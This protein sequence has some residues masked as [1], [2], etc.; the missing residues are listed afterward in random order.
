M[1]DWPQNVSAV[2]REERA[3]TSDEAEE[4]NVD[5]LLAAG[6]DGV[7]DCGGCR[8]WALR[9]YV[10]PLDLLRLFTVQ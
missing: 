1:L 3:A 7:V 5:M 8:R 9:R 10:H 4:C 6:R 2:E